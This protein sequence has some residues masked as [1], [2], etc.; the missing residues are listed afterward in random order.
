M[1]GR[2]PGTREPGARNLPHWTKLPTTHATC[3]TPQPTPHTPV[4][5]AVKAAG[6]AESKPS[7]STTAPE[8]SKPSAPEAAA[9]TAP[10][11]VPAPTAA[12]SPEAAAP[13]VPTVDANGVAYKII[14][15]RH[16]E[17][18]WNIE[19]R[20][21]GWVDVPLAET[22]V[23]ESHRAAGVIKEEQLGIDMVYTSL[24]KRAIK[25]GMNIL[26]DLDMMYVP[27]IKNYRLN[28]RHYGALQ[29]LPPPHTH[30]HEHTFTR[31][32]SNTPAN[33]LHPHSASRNPKPD[34]LN[35]NPSSPQNINPET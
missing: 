20:F 16:G 18:Q 5:Q 19:N 25:T 3:H 1:R 2:Q 34:S 24:L 4:G 8:T 31:F 11:A 12:S 30:P 22:G 26:E 21:T 9:V 17:S 23:A 32:P 29:G 10:Y 28:E 27:M 7:D 6:V 13:F 35:L 33:T 15:V 14:L